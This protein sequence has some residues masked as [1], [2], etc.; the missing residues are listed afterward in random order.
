MNVDSHEKWTTGRGIRRCT[1]LPPVRVDAS[2][3]D[4]DIPAEQWTIGHGIVRVEAI[5][6]QTVDCSTWDAPSAWLELLVPT[7][8]GSPPLHAVEQANRAIGLLQAD[9]RLTYDA[10]RSHLEGEVFVIALV[11]VERATEEQLASLVASLPPG[12]PPVRVARAA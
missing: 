10:M 9:A 11:P 1:A 8:P 2:A 4:A 12:S 7:A 6:A 3:W 5:P